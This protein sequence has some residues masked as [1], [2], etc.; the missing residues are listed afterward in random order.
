MR[1][2]RTMQL[3]VYCETGP[4]HDKGL[5]RKALRVQTRSLYKRLDGIKELL[6]RPAVRARIAQELAAAKG[7][8]CAR[9]SAP[10]ADHQG[11]AVSTPPGREKP[12]DET[13]V[14]FAKER[15]RKRTGLAQGANPARLCERRVLPAYID[16]S[17]FLRTALF[18]VV[19]VASGYHLSSAE[20]L[21]NLDDG[22][23]LIN[24]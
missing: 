14:P 15:Q 12:F 10:R 4:K 16:A 11:G 8:S 13:S 2:G 7:T 9:P 3:R 20:M 6:S 24:E 18:K 23:C 17:A 21:C 1:R 19:F 22:V 5:I